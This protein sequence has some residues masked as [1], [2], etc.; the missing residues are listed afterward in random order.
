MQYRSFK[1]F[2][3]HVRIKAFPRTVCSGT[4]VPFSVDILY[5]P[6][7]DILRTRSRKDD[8]EDGNRCFIPVSAP[9]HVIL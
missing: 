2:G 7:H 1:A 3:K 6:G 5:A 8:F 4:T 9:R